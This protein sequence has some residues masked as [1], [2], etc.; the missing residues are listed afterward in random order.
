MHIAMLVTL[1][2]IFN[3]QLRYSTLITNKQ[4]KQNL[5]GAAIYGADTPG[6]LFDSSVKAWNM[7]NLKTLLNLLRKMNWKLPGINTSYLYFGGCSCVCRS[8][9]MCMCICGYMSHLC[10]I[11]VYVYAYVC[12]YLCM[13]LCIY[14]YMR[15]LLRLCL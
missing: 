11:Y 12:M 6:S 10:L 4:N 14:V 9:C 3:I 1:L 5:I 13:N 7:N 2:S 15:V 8:M